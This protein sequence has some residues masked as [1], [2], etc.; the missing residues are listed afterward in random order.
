MNIKTVKIIN[1]LEITGVF[2]AGLM[3]DN[4]ITL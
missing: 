2:L 4:G 3:S 1:I